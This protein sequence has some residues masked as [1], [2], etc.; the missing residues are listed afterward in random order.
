MLDALRVL[1]GECS[2][3]SEARWQRLQENDKEWLSFGQENLDCFV[4]RSCGKELAL[5]S[6]DFVSRNTSLGFHT[7]CFKKFIDKRRI[8]AAS[9]K[10]NGVTC[11]VQLQKAPPD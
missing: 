6:L 1:Y 2:T 11:D 8:E 4:P 5:E 7:F 3:T 9:A 10:K